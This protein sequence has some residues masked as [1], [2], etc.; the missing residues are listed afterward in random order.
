MRYWLYNMAITLATPLGAGYLA[1]SS[2]HRAAIGR[3]Y[4]NV[5]KMP[6]PSIW[7]HACSV[8][9]V[10]VAQ[11][12][13]E[14]LARQ[15]PDIPILLT[16]STVTGHARA[17]A[18]ADTSALAWFPIDHPLSVAHF[19]RQADPR[20]LI[21]IET[22]LWP[23]VLRLTSRQGIPVALVNGRI[24][25]RH[26]QRY[27]RSGHIVRDMLS[28]IAVAGVQ[29]ELYADRFARLGMNRAA[30]QI[31]GNLKFDS[32]PE[33]PDHAAKDVLRS[34]CGIPLNAPILVFGSTRP[35]DERRAIDC[36]QQLRTAFPDLYLI[37]APRHV[38][39]A[40]EIVR[41]FSDPVRLRTQ[42]DH[43]V[44][45]NEPRPIIVDTHGELLDF[46]A[47]ATIAVIGG[48]FDNAIQGHN[49]IE[50]AAMGVPML[51]GPHMRNFASAAESLVRADA[52]M[53]INDSEQLLTEMAALL[54]NPERRSQMGR[55]G[56]DI[57]T[58]NRGA[59]RRTIEMLDSHAL[60]P[61]DERNAD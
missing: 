50:P 7:I 46:Y 54:R 33:P 48:S 26:Y 23:N 2:R 10:A 41:L 35:G 3:F 44:N 1:A 51:F 29:D 59:L 58:A 57:V 30:I 40:P 52:A 24:S 28:H 53:Q 12:V 17:K 19:L 47:I 45:Q 20:L 37:I 6:A 60:L 18:L 31:T 56:Q 27:I 16:T 38:E 36:W 14:A 32:V 15:C 34:A 5:P 25:E 55:H 61:T 43:G 42:M 9:E 21:L 4:P 49:P 11:P 8:G 13:L 22:E 39:R